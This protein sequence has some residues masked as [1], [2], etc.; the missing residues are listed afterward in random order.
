MTQGALRN[1][2]AVARVGGSRSRLREAN[3]RSGSCLLRV[4]LSKP[5]GRSQHRA[6]G[7][8]G[9]NGAR[10]QGRDGRAIRRRSVT[11]SSLHGQTGSDGAAVPGSRPASTQQLVGRRVWPA[12]YRDTFGYIFLG[13][14]GTGAFWTHSSGNIYDGVVVAALASSTVISD[15][16]PDVPNACADETKP[17]HAARADRADFAPHRNPARPTRRSARRARPGERPHARRLIPTLIAPPT[18][19]E[20]MWD[21]LRPIRQAVGLVSNPLKALYDSL[22]DEQKAQLNALADSTSARLHADFPLG[23]LNTKRHS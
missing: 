11:P 6:G 7:H 14:N 4:C 5:C 17:A 9:Q 15:K 19:L 12:A 1:L 3:I 16:P 8:S 21:R 22:S 23:C 10:P 13:A 20:M 18:R 2:G